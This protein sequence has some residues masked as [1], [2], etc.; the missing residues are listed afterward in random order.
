MIKCTEVDLYDLLL[1]PYLVGSTSCS[2][3]NGG[4]SHICLPNPSGHR[5]FCP[6][7]VQL[8]PG[9]AFTC[10]GG[11]VCCYACH[12]RFDRL[13]HGIFWKFISVVYIHKN[14]KVKRRTK[15]VQRNYGSIC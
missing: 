8:K 11:K 1:V 5:C 10:Q 15:Y 7:G 14:P 13:I 6:E 12:T 4:C 9:D 3:L 2:K